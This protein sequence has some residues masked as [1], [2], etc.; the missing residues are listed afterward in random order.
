MVAKPSPV[1]C[2]TSGRAPISSTSVMGRPPKPLLETLMAKSP[3]NWLPMVSRISDLKLDA[4]EA[5]AVT[6]ATPIN[7]GAAVRAVRFGLRAAF[8]RAMPPV[9][10]RIF[11]IG[12]PSVKATG[13]EIPGPMMRTAVKTNSTPRP[14]TPSGA[15]FAAAVIATMPSAKMMKAI[16]NRLTLL[17]IVSSAVSRN[18][19]SGSTRP[20]RSAGNTAEKIVTSTPTI[21]VV[22]N[23]LV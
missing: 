9:T 22:T 1:A 14:S 15:S 5:N 6:S 17:P 23:A 4:N 20:A 8:C 7:T 16:T 18:A 21:M 10:P 11:R 13:R 12:R 2:A 19:A 3:L